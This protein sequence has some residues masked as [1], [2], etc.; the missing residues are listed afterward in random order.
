LLY[1]SYYHRYDD[2]IQSEEWTFIYCVLLFGGH[3]LSFLVTAWSSG[4]RAKISFTTAA[5]LEEASRVRVRPKKGRGT[6]EIV[7]L[8]KKMVRQPAVPVEGRLTL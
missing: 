3:A 2:F 8:E 5:S 6:G 4:I 1:Y 7:P